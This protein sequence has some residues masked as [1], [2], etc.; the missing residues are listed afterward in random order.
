MKNYILLF[1]SSFILNNL[2]GQDDLGLKKSDIISK[3]DKCRI[4]DSSDL[5][6]LNCD[7]LI[8]FYN[9]DQDKKLCNFY[10]FEIPRAQL[11]KFKSQLLDQGYTLY[12]NLDSYP[13]I[14]VL[15]G[16]NKNKTTSAA[17]YENKK[18]VISLLKYDL[19]GDESTNKVGVYAE[20]YKKEMFEKK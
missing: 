13:I 2:F 17:V 3:Y 12:A 6:T 8:Q 15:K 1:L 20:Y 7:D 11:D 16:G 14:L 18:F 4:E 9:F 10:G 19:V 5:L